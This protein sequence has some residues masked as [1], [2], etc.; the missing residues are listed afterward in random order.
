MLAGVVEVRYGDPPSGR[1]VRR[2]REATLASGPSPIKEGGV[3]WITGGAG[4]LGR[5]LAEHLASV[6]GIRIVL[7]GRRGPDQQDLAWIDPLR[8]RGVVIDYIQADVG[9]RKSAET[10]FSRIKADYGRIDGV[11]HSAGVL[12]DAYLLK[13]TPEEIA[14]V[15]RP[16][17]RG[18]VVLDD[19]TRDEPLD[20]MALFSSGSGA[21]GNVGQCDYAAANAFLDA[22]ARSRNLR[23]EKGARSGVTVSLGWPLWQDG[24]LHVDTQ[25]WDVVRKQTGAVPL[26]SALGMRL[27]EHAMRSPYPD[28]L[29]ASGDRARLRSRLLEQEVMTPVRHHGRRRFDAGSRETVIAYFKNLLGAPLKVPLDRIESDAP[30]EEYGIDSVMVV[31]LNSRLEEAFGP[32]SR[33]LFFE[34]QTLDELV[35]YFIEAHSEVL[36]EVIGASASPETVPAP[37]AC[38]VNFESLAERYLANDISDDELFRSI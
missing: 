18:A 31:G 2:L 25:T 5:I 21:L 36:A 35:D 3:Y 34:C 29:I 20:F 38:G 22:F 37:D 11:I 23:V 1:E 15:L 13:K 7:S 4:G 30:F 6:Q 14:Q 9:D 27:F 17:V 26:P 32:L 24:G 28:V 8:E 10:A 33:T 16:K 19:I 12:R